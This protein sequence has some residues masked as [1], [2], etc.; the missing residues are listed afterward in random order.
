M[1]V[2]LEWPRRATVGAIAVIGVTGLA[3]FAGGTGVLY[4]DCS[5]KSQ[6]IALTSIHRQTP[7][8]HASIRSA[9][10]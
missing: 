8:Y 6:T 3:S 4:C 2:D 1:P 7:G 9:K 5:V 10:L